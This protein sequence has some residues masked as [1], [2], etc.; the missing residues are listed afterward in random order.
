MSGWRA[1]A[2]GGV[3]C[4]D[5]QAL[6]AP[7]SPPAIADAL[8]RPDN[9]GAAVWVIGR[10]TA[11]GAAQRQARSPAAAAEA[12]RSEQNDPPHESRTSV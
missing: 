12:R 11:G 10:T 2:A 4:D 6:Q 1:G 7:S 3:L 8:R 5:P 9:T